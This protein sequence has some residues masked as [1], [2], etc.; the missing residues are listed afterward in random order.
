MSIANGEIYFPMNIRAT[1]LFTELA[2]NAEVWQREIMI[3]RGPEVYRNPRRTGQIVPQI[4]YTGQK[5]RHVNL[6][7]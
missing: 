4:D 1:P 5:G 6:L 3:K 2:K 7:A